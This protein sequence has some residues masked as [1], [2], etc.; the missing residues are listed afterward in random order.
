MVGRFV[1]LNPDSHLIESMAINYDKNSIGQ[2]L[3]IMQ[4]T[5]NMSVLAT[6]IGNPSLAATNLDWRDFL[7]W[8]LNTETNLIQIRDEANWRTLYDFRDSGVEQIAYG[9]FN[10]GTSAQTAQ[11]MEIT[12]A[13]AGDGTAQLQVRVQFADSSGSL[14]EEIVLFNLINNVWLRAS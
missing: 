10:A 6:T 4:P 9:R 13:T 1:R 5:S 8:R 14:R 11:V 2:M 12:Q 3:T 7:E